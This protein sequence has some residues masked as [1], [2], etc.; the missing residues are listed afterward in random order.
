MSFFSYCCCQGMT[1][2][3]PPPPPPPPPSESSI[4]SSISVS[5]SSLSVSSSAVSIV[6][7]CSGC[8]D[9]FPRRWKLT[10]TENCQVAGTG[11]CAAGCG[12]ISNACTASHYG[13]FLMQFHSRSLSGRPSFAGLSPQSGCTLRYDS[14]FKQRVISGGV[15]VD[16]PGDTS[17]FILY[18]TCTT[19]NAI[20]LVIGGNYLGT[21]YPWRQV[22]NTGF[23]CLGTNT[24]TQL[25]QT[26]SSYWLRYIPTCPNGLPQYHLNA[27][28]VSISPSP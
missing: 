9:A 27:Y 26:T 1:I 16:A 15:C 3:P 23:S 12:V 6:E 4:S 13:E 7:G 5:S 24:A 10:V 18:L 11:D 14:V 2:T 21:F 20:E 28:Q 17:A 22:Y 19:S 8:C 25:T